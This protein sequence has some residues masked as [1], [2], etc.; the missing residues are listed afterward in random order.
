MKFE[1]DGYQYE[2]AANGVIH[3]RNPKPFVYDPEYSAIYDT[4]AYRRSSDMLQYS[5][6]TFASACHGRPIRSL[7]DV[8]FGNGAFLN[9]AKQMVESATGMDVTGVLVPDG[10]F[11][12][13]R[14]FPV[15]C[16]TFFDVLEHIHDLHFVRYIPAETVIITLPYCHFHSKDA[17]KEWF[18]TWHHKKP[19]EHVHFF[20]LTSLTRFMHENDWDFVATSNMEDFVRKPRDHRQNILAAGFKKRN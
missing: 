5:R 14:F 17:G 9:T 18:D 13:E 12:T 10:C 7:I 15:D 3:Q 8:G 16:V 4:E 2:V 11:Q 1:S 6:L 20:D 19:N